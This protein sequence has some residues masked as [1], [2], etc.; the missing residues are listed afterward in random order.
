MSNELK[1]AYSEVDAILKLME[2]KYIEKIPQNLREI[3]ENRKDKNY[4]PKI[5]VNKS[6]LEQKLLNK[7]LSIL[8][9]LNL[10]YWCEDEKEKQKLLQIYAKNDR[11]KE[12][13][14]RERYNPDNIF[15]NRKKVITNEVKI[16]EKQMIEYKKQNLFKKV[17]NKIMKF[18]RRNR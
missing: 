3:F 9:I 6:L 13:E 17:F 14:A 7:T 15:K 1:K 12:E 5:D 11:I 10:N 16:E 2:Q 8:A 18:F 4:T